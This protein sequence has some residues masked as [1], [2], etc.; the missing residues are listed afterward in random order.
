MQ[1]LVSGRQWREWDTLCRHVG[2]L[3]ICRW[4]PSGFCGP[5]TELVGQELSGVKSKGFWCRARVAP[6]LSVLGVFV[7]KSARV[8]TR[9][10]CASAVFAAVPYPGAVKSSWFVFGSETVLLGYF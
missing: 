5:Q 1:G 7:K 3:F 4:A 6:A 10:G 8:A 9:Q 2:E